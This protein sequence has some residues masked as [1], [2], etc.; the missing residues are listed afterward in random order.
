MRARSVT[1]TLSFTMVT[2]TYPVKTKSGP[3][4]NEPVAA[5][6]QPAWLRGRPDSL[7]PNPPL[8]EPA[9][10]AKR[11]NAEPPQTGNPA[12]ARAYSHAPKS[13]SGVPVFVPDPGLEP[14]LMSLARGD[15]RPAS[16]RANISP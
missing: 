13:R 15:G 2:F 5:M 4:K 8:S 10:P 11:K 7:Q 6:I 16:P 12:S 3:V 14:T 9:P 1:R